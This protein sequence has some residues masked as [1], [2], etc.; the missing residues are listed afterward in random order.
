MSHRLVSGI[1]CY[2]EILC[3][4][5]SCN[6]VFHNFMIWQRKQLFDS[7]SFFYLWHFFQTW[8]FWWWWQIRFHCLASSNWYVVYLTFTE[9]CTYRHLSMGFT[10][11]SSSSRIRFW[12][13]W[14]NWY[15]GMA[16]LNWLL[17]HCT[18]IESN[19]SLPYASQYS[20]T[21]S[22]TTIK[23][24]PIQ[25]L[26]ERDIASNYIVVCLLERNMNIFKQNIWVV[27][28]K[29]FHILGILLYFCHNWSTLLPVNLDHVW[30]FLY[31]LFLSCR[32]KRVMRWAELFFSNQ[33]KN[34]PVT[35]YEFV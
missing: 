18:I 6:G 20:T 3:Y 34:R 23:S 26:D 19:L 24:L 21:S 32:S 16:T 33:T 7:D 9:S 11:W 4:K 28:M 31:R 25:A 17:V 12:W 8:W 14:K 2:R 13:W 5:S 1:S 10:R 30:S 27:Q 22:T 29:P 15:C 35:P